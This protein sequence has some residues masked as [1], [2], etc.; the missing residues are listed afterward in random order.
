MQRAEMPLIQGQDLE[1]TY[2]SG[3]QP[4]C[5]IRIQPPRSGQQRLAQ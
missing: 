3:H 2:P 5:V 1:K 4:A